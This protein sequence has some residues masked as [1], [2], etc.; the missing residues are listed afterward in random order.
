MRVGWHVSFG[1]LWEAELIRLIRQEGISLRETARKLEVDVNTVRFQ[2]QRIENHKKQDLEVLPT[3]DS[4]Q[5][6]RLK[7]HSNWLAILKSHPDL[8]RK[9]VRMQAK[10]DFAWLYR[11]DYKWLYEHQPNRIVRT[12]P[13]P[14][15]D[16]QE[17]DRGIAK[18]IKPTV[19]EILQT[20]GLPRRITVSLIGKQL[21]L[22]ALF[23]KKLHKL[24][25]VAKKLKFL[26]D[27]DESFAER[28][29]SYAI[30]TLREEGNRLEPWL[31]LRRA[32]IR[33]SPTVHK[34]IEVQLAIYHEM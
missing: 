34:I 7:R 22:R 30:G 1:Q 21:G 6:E 9:A 3:V 17:R 26:T 32:S 31:V 33:G 5:E 14:K 4:L 11:H 16:W 23:E 24:P 12:P 15:V 20:P 10:A 8:G 25:R 18:R 2:L 13:K 29:I 27:S 19:Q 28:R